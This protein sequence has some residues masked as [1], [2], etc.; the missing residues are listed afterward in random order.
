MTNSYNLINTKKEFENKIRMGLEKDLLKIAEDDLL[1][2]KL[3]DANL[4]TKKRGP[5]K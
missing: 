3:Q 1:G 4:T 5:K 2:R